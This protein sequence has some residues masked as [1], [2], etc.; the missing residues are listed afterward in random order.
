MIRPGWRRRCPRCWGPCRPRPAAPSI[1]YA[2]V[3]VPKRKPGGSWGK[4]AGP[5]GQSCHV[6]VEIRRASR[7]FRRPDR[8]DGSTRH[9]F[10]FGAHY[11]PENVGSGRWC[12]TTTT[13]CA[14][15]E[16]FPDHPHARRRDRDLGA[17]RGAGAHRRPTG[18]TAPWSTPGTGAGAV[19]P[20]T[21]VTARARSRPGS[22]PTRFVQAWLRPDAAGAEPSY[23]RS[24]RP[25][26]PAGRLVPVASAER[27][28]AAA[29][30][31]RLGDVLGRAARPRATP[32]RCPTTRAS[33]SS[34]ARGALVRSSPGRAAARRRR[35]PDHRPAGPRASP[36]RP[37][38][39][40][41][42]DA[43]TG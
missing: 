15:G 23:A 34:S 16:G 33:T 37:D 21:G 24:P 10:S 3:L 28:D 18:A 19:G 8:R 39:A 42:L 43:S 38:R 41:G 13:C 14:P 36:R 6:T 2:A 27:A 5:R 26:L 22:A 4:A 35:V 20:A 32:S 9:S 11:D 7:R 30:R 29:D 12:A 17:R 25:T 1:W 31:H 40:A